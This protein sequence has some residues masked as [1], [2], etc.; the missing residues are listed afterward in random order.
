ML[1]SICVLIVGAIVLLYPGAAL[2]QAP[3]GSDSVWNVS[4]W[5]NQTLSG[6]PVL[7]R[8]ESTLRYDW[9]TGSPD[10]TVP[11]DHFS[12][13]WTRG[14]DVSAGTYRFTATTDDGMRIWVDDTP[15]LDAWY[16][17]AAT[18]YY[19]DQYLA[20]GQHVITVE[21]YEDTGL[22]VAEVSWQLA[23][24]SAGG[25]E[26]EYYNNMTL[27]GTPVLTRNDPQIDFTWLGGSPDPGVVQADH[28]SARWT[29][30][31]YFPPGNYRFD[32]TVDD[33]ARLFVNGE[34]LIDVWYD[35]VATLY[36][37]GIYLPGGDV[38]LE[39]QYYED[40]GL[41]Q[42]QL[43]W[44]PQ[45]GGGPPA[46]QPGTVIVDDLGPGFVEGGTAAY[47]HTAPD[48]FDGGFLWTYNN[49][50]VVP[51]YNWVEWHPV[52]TA[53]TYEVFAYIPLT[54]ATTTQARYWVIYGGGAAL[55]VIDQSTNGGAWVSLGT[56][57]FRGDGTEYVSLAD[58][59]F[60]PGLS[61]MV[62]FDAIRWEPR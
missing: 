31:S 39:L 3:G 54:D 38:T 51:N 33:G 41:A 35:Q 44:S 43:S 8:S 12:A 55:R 56:Y 21:Y 40:T 49:E 26:A 27:S 5:A 25:W 32:L 17:Q 28:F 15:V 37:D 19:R 36:T 23:S 45:T 58:V 18:T 60:E 29:Q 46:G 61:T 6:A 47:W 11:A 53:G 50:R 7:V 62:A 14:I 52:L 48:G 57:S 30:T 59:T 24:Q 34:L 1:R 2:A 10:P 16:D 20:A 9:G 22:A 13:R 42:V 4:Y